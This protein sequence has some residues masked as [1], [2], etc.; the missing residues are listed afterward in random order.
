[1]LQD[2]ASSSLASAV[3]ESQIRVLSCGHKVLAHPAVWAAACH[4]TQTPQVWAAL[5]VGD[6]GADEEASWT[7]PGIGTCC[8]VLML[9]DVLHMPGMTLGCINSSYKACTKMGPPS[10]CESMRMLLVCVQ[11]GGEGAFPFEEQ[12]L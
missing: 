2:V 6:T 4:V 7:G 9:Q 1:M 5:G 3:R 10:T 12:Q 8:Q 11:V